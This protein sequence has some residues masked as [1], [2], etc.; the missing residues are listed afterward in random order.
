MEETAERDSIVLC[1]GREQLKVVVDQYV[2]LSYYCCDPTAEQDKCRSCL[3]TPF[4]F[5]VDERV[6]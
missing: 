6:P 2:S 3:G 4:M 5:R 1:I